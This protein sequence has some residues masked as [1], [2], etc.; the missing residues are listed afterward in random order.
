MKPVSRT[1]RESGNEVC[2]RNR[3]VDC[4]MIARFLALQQL[5][6]SSCSEDILLMECIS[7][8][9]DTVGQS[10]GVDTRRYIYTA[11]TGQVAD[12]VYISF[13]YICTRSFTF[14]PILKAVVGVVVVTITSTWLHTFSTAC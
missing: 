13:R 2:S 6:P 1:G 11:N 12:V 14:S 3:E 5:H 7:H 10:V 4:V 8:E 9:M